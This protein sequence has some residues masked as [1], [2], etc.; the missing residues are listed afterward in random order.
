M[1]DTSTRPVKVTIRKK[2]PSIAPDKTGHTFIH[3]GGDL[4][5]RFKRLATEAGYTRK[6]N[7]FGVM[8]FEQALA[9]AE[10]DFADQSK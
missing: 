4:K 2:D 7:E 8:L 5:A 3:F 6:M 10:K 1:A 9:L